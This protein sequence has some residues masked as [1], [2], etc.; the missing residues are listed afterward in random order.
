MRSG[1][2]GTSGASAAPMSRMKSMAGA[3]GAQ[4]PRILAWSAKGV[5]EA[6]PPP[7]GRDE[8]RPGACLV[9]LG[10]PEHLQ[11]ARQDVDGLVKLVVRVR[12]GADEA[13]RYRDLHR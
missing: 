7:P 6:V 4:I 3:A 8:H 12:D 5:P 1:S 13:S 2:G 9:H 10:V 11:P